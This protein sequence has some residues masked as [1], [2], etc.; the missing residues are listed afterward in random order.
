M[1]RF[2]LFFTVLLTTVAFAQ[3]DSFQG[4]QEDPDMEALRKWVR[5]KRLVTVKEIGG[6]L[7]ISGEVRT[8]M[9][10]FSEKKAGIKQRGPNGA[11]DLPNYAYDVQFNLMLDYHAHRTWA[12][13]KLEFDNDCGMISGSMDH[14]ALARAYMGGRLYDGETASFDLEIGRRFLGNVFDS[15]IEFSSLY[16]GVLA[17]YSN[18]YEIAGDFYINAGA[19]LIDDRINHYGFVGE[20]GMLRIATTGLYVK[21]S[22]ID[23]KKNFS[24][25]SK[26]MRYNY[27]VSQ[28][29]LGYQFNVEKWDKFLK[30]YMSGLINTS[31]TPV[32][33][34]DDQKAN[35]GGYIGISLGQVRKQGDWAFDLNF[36]VV[37]AQAIPEFD[38]GGIK[39]GNAARVGLYTE[40]LDGTGAATTKENAVGSCN[41][42]GVQIDLLYAITS[43][44][45]L[46]ESFQMSSTLNHDIGPDLDYKRFK[47]E[48]I[49]AF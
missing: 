37:E 18:A 43:N 39:R 33:M 12:S 42:K 41:Y 4:R 14:L 25:L 2:I 21:Y 28:A 23:W 22:I 13:A 9:E 26:R 30:F 5:Q 17:K 32:S 7:S 24:N 47:A 19:F 49:Y 45:T 16:D 10:A 34:T 46:L 3:D 40:N 8:E 1:K 31:A 36:Q 38:E 15:K 6:D 48:L 27:I 44:L 11:T 35:L 20:V 29:I